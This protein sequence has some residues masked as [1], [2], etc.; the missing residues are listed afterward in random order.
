[1]KI[2]Q[3]DNTNKPDETSD[4]VGQPQIAKNQADSKNFMRELQKLQKETYA[5]ELDTE[6]NEF[7]DMKAEGSIL[8]NILA[9]LPQKQLDLTFWQELSKVYKYTSQIQKPLSLAEEPL[10][11]FSKEKLQVT[12]EFPDSEKAADIQKLVVQYDPNLKSIAA[13]LLTSAEAARLLQAQLDTLAENLQKH[14]IK[15][16]SMEINGEKR[17]QQS[18]SQQKRKKKNR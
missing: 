8:N 2:N 17:K 9:E 5:D 12:I 18:E 11:D 14:N 6:Q 1:M 4:L 15:L 7:L 10:V 13:E 3:N 16:S